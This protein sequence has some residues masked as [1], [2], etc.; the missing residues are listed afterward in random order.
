MVEQPQ[1]SKSLFVFNDNEEQYLAFK[2][3][4]KKAGCSRGSGNGVMRPY[5][6][7]KPRRS[8]GV[9]T[10]SG[11]KG[12]ARL[13]PEVKAVID[14]SIAAI[15]SLIESGAYEQVYFSQSR[16]NET[17]GSGTYRPAEEVKAYIFNALLN[18]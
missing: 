5:Q 17:L 18:L 2:S 13:T 14:D 11:G 1:Y 6:C 10:G 3:G 4:D 7:L 12:Y 16:G 9:P 15:R 8:A